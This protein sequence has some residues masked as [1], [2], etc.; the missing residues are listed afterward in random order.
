MIQSNN[1]PNQ[2]NISQ[3]IPVKVKRAASK[4]QR[5][6]KGKQDV[7]TYQ[8][9]KKNHRY[10]KNVISEIYNTEKQY[11][12]DMKILSEKVLILAQQYINQ[13]NIKT[14]FMNCNQIA[15]WNQEFIRTMEIGYQGYIG[16]VKDM[17]KPY[18]V[19]FEGNTKQL[20]NVTCKGFR[21]YFEYCSQ[22]SKSNQLID[23]LKQSDQKF[24][25]FLS[26]ISPELRGMDLS[27]FLVK[28]VQRL[29]KYI[30]LFKDLEKHT[31]DDHPDM[32]NIKFLHKYF[33]DINEENNKSIDIYI[34][35]LQI[36]E[37]C[38]QFKLNKIDLLQDPLRIYK[39]EE[40]LNIIQANKELIVQVHALS[41]LLIV[42]HDNK[43]FNQVKLD[44]LSFVKDQP[45]T[46]YFNNLF[47]IVGVGEVLQCFAE[48]LSIKKK[49]IEQFEKLIQLNR[50]QECKKE[51]QSG[52]LTFMRYPVQV[53]IVGTE[54]RNFQSFQKH[55]Q[56]I[57]EISINKVYQ[58]IYVRF[59]EI[60]TMY[61]KYSKKYPTI[62]FP[63]F[64][65]QSWLTYQKTKSIEERKFV[66]EGFLQTLLQSKQTQGDIQILN[67]LKL[68]FNFF[69]L[70]Q[71]VIDQQKSIFS[72]YN[73]TLDG[74]EELK[75]QGV[76][77]DKLNMSAGEILKAVCIEKESRKKS[78]AQIQ[79]NRVVIWQQKYYTEPNMKRVIITMPDGTLTE[80]GVDDKA[81][82]SE[83]LPF[84]AG[85]N[86][87]IYYKDFRLY[88][89]D[90]LKKQRILDDDEIIS[91]AYDDENQ[92]NHGWLNKLEQIITASNTDVVIKMRKYLYMPLQLEEFDY[93]EDP[94]RLIYLGFSIL[95]D[96]YEGKYYL[97][98]KDYC[99][100][101]AL[102]YHLKYQEKIEI[103][104]NTL[105]LD[106]IIKVIPQE[107]YSGKSD[108]EWKE[109]SKEC[110]VSLNQEL[111]RISQINKIEK[112]QKKENSQYKFTDKR[113][114][115][116]LIIINA[117]QTFT[118]GSMAIFQ[119]QTYEQTQIYFKQAGMEVHATM[120]LGFSAYKIYFLNPQKKLKFR[121]LDYNKVNWVISYPN[122]IIFNFENFKEPLRFDTFQSYEIKLLVEQYKDIHK[123]N[124]EYNLENLFNNDKSQF[125]KN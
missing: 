103:S 102:Y 50:E 3:N 92:N 86:Q 122:Q 109:F 120:Y 47:Q 46:K 84:V 38:D 94:T 44:S 100:F 119:V 68:P 63:K 74:L 49:A 26:L 2:T 24:K 34:G 41:D 117:S 6:F 27:S 67:D 78:I 83:V 110:I 11:C 106:K 62:E 40:K 28:P 98:F 118:Q 59:S 37:L 88:L 22:F 5:W 71:I 72:K 99:L 95:E 10:R 4:L 36:S 73:T 76:L 69:E 123:F 23:K 90:Q 12:N 52:K 97:G 82:V 114:L 45:D 7:K 56:Y 33:R 48:T 58:N 107:V 35:R 113:C 87:L 66:I 17:Y 43:L 31:E 16:N 21:Y 77:I 13:E 81:K 54:E 18:W 64:P 93:R 60:V 25:Q 115:A 111:D 30:L 116:A 96:V 51:L 14:I 9:L 8:K 19:V 75:I 80:I 70:P 124:K 104:L 20:M 32:K 65:N 55:T 42:I 91:K 89:I 101:A 105:Q 1:Q 108:F 79:P 53:V 85:Y 57:T 61:Q 29:P 125:I 15:Q 112:L 121:E 39:F